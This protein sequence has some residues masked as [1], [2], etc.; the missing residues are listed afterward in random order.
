MLTNFKNFIKYTNFKEILK[1]VVTN[2]Q[3]MMGTISNQSTS[4]RVLKSFFLICDFDFN[5]FERWWFLF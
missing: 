3:S 4:N 2:S 1:P 5:S